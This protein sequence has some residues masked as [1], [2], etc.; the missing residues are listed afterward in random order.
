MTVDLQNPPERY[1]HCAVRVD[2][3]G[4]HTVVNDLTFDDA[5]WPHLETLIFLIYNSAD[6]RDPEAF[7]KLSGE[8]KISDRTFTVKVVLA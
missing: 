4:K 6:L 3:K 2:K 1:W 8:Q 7:E 5:K